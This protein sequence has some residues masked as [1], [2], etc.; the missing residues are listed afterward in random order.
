MKIA[1]LSDIHG[2]FTA[3]EAVV[4]DAKKKN[5]SEFWLL[6]DIVMP[7]P[8]TADLLDLLKSLPVTAN[9]RGNWD[10][11]LLESLSGLENGDATDV[12][13]TRLSQYLA[14]NIAESDIEMIKNMPLQATKKVGNLTF[15]LSHNLPDKNYGGALMPA[16]EQKNFD[17]LFSENQADFA[18][19]GHVHHQTLRYDS[20]DRL[21][22]NPGTVGQAFSQQLKF[23][24]DHRAQY[25]ILEIDENNQFDVTFRKIT[26]DIQKELAL[27]KAKQLPYFELYKEQLETGITHTHDLGFLQKINQKNDYESQVREFFAK[28]NSVSADK[29]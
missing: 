11:C 10:D 17:S 22:I 12:Y 2:N 5:V 1:V 28:R 9:L 4:A 7:G 16:A 20:E 24:T 8:G 6:G 19:Y 15:T 26:Y 18:L 3:L 21:I 23:R 14:E 25:A 29:N 27:A 13:I